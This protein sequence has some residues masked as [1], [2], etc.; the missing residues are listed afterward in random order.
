MYQKKE[1][2]INIKSILSLIIVLF[3]LLKVMNIVKSIDN[4]TF[5]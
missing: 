4:K 1:C 2:L 3:G 5:K